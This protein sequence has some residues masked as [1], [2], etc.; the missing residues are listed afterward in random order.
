MISAY[1]N[2]AICQLFDMIECKSG[3]RFTTF[4]ASDLQG[5]ENIAAGKRDYMEDT[6]NNLSH[7]IYKYLYDPNLAFDFRFH[8]R[9]A[10]APF[11]KTNKPWV[12]IMFSTKQVRSLTNVLSRQYQEVKY[13]EKGNPFQVEIK[14]VS[15]PVNMALVSNDIDK[16][17]NTTERIAHWF[18]RI[19]NFHY[20]HVIDIGNPEK[21]GLRIKESRVG[22]AMDIREVDLSK[23]DTE[24]RGSIVTSAFTFDLVYFTFLTPS[25]S[26]KLLQRIILEIGI[27]G[28]EERQIVFITENEME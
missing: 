5:Q 26:L 10:S 23:L 13:D 24:H 8:Q 18:D 6:P 17:Y 25:A 2:N 20:D 3:V 11:A 1:I 9:L 15:V 4:T 22:Q 27:Q 14:R 21:G 28:T 19:V 12:T 7:G 16:L